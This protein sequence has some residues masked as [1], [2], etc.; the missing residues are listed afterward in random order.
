MTVQHT[1]EV[2]TVAMKTASAMTYG[3]SA[4]AVIF[5]LT[6]HEFAAFGG[7]LVAVIGLVAKICID[8]HFK[9]AH[10]K[11]ARERGKTDEGGG[12]E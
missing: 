8:W 1:P 5:G 11:L 3:G 7:L 10:L 4:T 6:A 9:S 12:D 2:A